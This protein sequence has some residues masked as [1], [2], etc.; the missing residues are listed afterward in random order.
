MWNQTGSKKIC[1]IIVRKNYAE[2]T[3]KDSYFEALAITFLATTGVQNWRQE[4]VFAKNQ[5]VE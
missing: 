4:R 1:T 2:R 3:A 5:I